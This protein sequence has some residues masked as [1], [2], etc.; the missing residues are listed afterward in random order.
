M[1]IA[2]NIKL[3]DSGKILYFKSSNVVY[4]LVKQ[5]GIYRLSYWNDGDCGEHEIIEN[6][7]TNIMKDN[8]MTCSLQIVNMWIVGGHDGHSKHNTQIG[9]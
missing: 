7:V 9:D 4:C 3:L 6:T 2:E 8:Q 5:Y 1:D